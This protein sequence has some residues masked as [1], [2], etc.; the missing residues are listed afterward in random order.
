MD[1][2]RRMGSCH[3]E[4]A[5]SWEWKPRRARGDQE[6]TFGEAGVRGTSLEDW[7]VGERSEPEARILEPAAVGGRPQRK[8]KEVRPWGPG[9]HALAPTHT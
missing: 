2:E 5:C 8:P 3:P 7:K 1:G 9:L 4:T 6:L